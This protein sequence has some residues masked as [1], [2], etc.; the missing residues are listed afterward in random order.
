VIVADYDNNRVQV[1]RLVVGADGISAHLEFVRSLG[2]GRGSAEGQL[3]SPFDSLAI[4]LAQP[5]S[6]AMEGN[7][8]VSRFALDGTVVGIFAETG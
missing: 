3:S 2:S 7:A 5:C 4:L 1:I 8:R 6:K